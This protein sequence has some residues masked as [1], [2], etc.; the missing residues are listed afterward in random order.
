VQES[1]GLTVQNPGKFAPTLVASLPF[2]VDN[3]EQGAVAVCRMSENGAFLPALDD[4]IPLLWVV[5]PQ[6]ALHLNG[7]PVT[8][9]EDVAGKKIITTTPSS[10]AIVAAYGGAPLSL[11]ITE[12]YEG[13]QRGTA[14]GT[15]INFTAF[16]GF[17]LDEVTTDHYIMPLGGAAGIVFMARDKWD[18]LSDDVRE[19]LARH[20]GCDSSREFGVFVDALEANAKATVANAGGHTI[21][22]ASAD[23]IG[24]AR[25]AMLPSIEAGFVERSPGGAELLQMFKDE[26]AAASAN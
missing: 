24:A 4:I 10:A 7:A 13:L 17:R 9:L 15:V 1:W 5:F 18:A 2:L 8:S 22:E 21:T 11:G 25:D 23:E 16:P 26:L 20:A 19:T 3:A 6:A 12:M 14:D